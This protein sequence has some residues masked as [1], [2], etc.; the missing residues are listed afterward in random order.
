MKKKSGGWRDQKGG[1]L[2]WWDFHDDFE[3]TLS[4]L[5]D[6]DRCLSF[7]SMD[8]LALGSSWFIVVPAL[9]QERVQYGFSNWEWA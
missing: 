2:T 9:T 7:Y 5:V 4:V 1:V 8:T 3:C 6:P